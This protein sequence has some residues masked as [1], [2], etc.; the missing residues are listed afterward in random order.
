MTL[1]L[2]FLFI[3]ATLIATG[4]QAFEDIP[5]QQNNAYVWDSY[6][7]IVRDRDGNCVRTIHWKEDTVP[8]GGEPKAVV[9]A[10]APMP[11]KAEP[12]A[13]SAKAVEEPVVEEVAAA[14]AVVEV[15]KP[16]DFSGFFKTD[17]FEL[18]DEAKS[19]LD[20]YAEYLQANPD[21]T[22]QIRGFTD[23]HG[24]AAYNQKLS[25]KRADSVKNYLESKDVDAKRMESIG[26]GEKYPVADNATSAGRA[27]NRRVE[28]TVTE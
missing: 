17:S 26:E 19:K 7:N 15:A 21:T 10:E 25:Q 3:S 5:H 18:T 6:G 2:P 22:L 14:V 24:S 9:N 12:V 8:C 1:R 13:E 16:A 28:L 4:A 20:G 23:S 27:K 11:K